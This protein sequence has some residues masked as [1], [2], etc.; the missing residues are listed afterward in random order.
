MNNQQY[1]PGED[2]IYSYSFC[3]MG[4]T[5]RKTVTKEAKFVRYLESDHT[6]AKIKAVGNRTET[7][8]PIE[9][10]RKREV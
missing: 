8:V 3:P 6:R 9:K 7:T 4:V 5:Q 2:I 10:I 1:K